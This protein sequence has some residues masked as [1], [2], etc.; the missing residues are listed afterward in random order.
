MSIATQ[1]GLIA[2]MLPPIPFQKNNVISVALGTI[3]AIGFMG[4]GYPDAFTAGAPGL[5]GATI[6]GTTNTLGGTFP[7]TNPSAGNST[8]LAKVGVSAGKGYNSL[9]LFDFLWYNTGITVT[10]T[11]AQTVNSV[12][13]PARDANGAT[14]GVG[15]TAWLLARGT[16]GNAST[17]NNTTIS[18]TNSNGTSGKTG[19]FSTFGSIASAPNGNLVP[20]SLASGDVGVQSIQS[21]TLG[22]SYVSGTLSLIMLRE[23]AYI[24]LSGR[25]GT[26]GV[27]MDWAQLNFPQLYN[28]TALS[29]YS[30]MTD[31]TASIILGEIVYAQG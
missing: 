20:F 3:S 11:T 14:S 19:S 9:V 4:I 6:D 8:Y 12:T 1:D 26:G 22:T 16:M 13:L 25:G 5:A 24:P 7:F 28:G 21:I 2:G 29:C 15:V 27:V 30:A 10:T 31:L 23:V 17:I 18:Y